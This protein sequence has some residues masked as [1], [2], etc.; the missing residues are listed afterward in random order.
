MP[1]RQSHAWIQILLQALASP[2]D[3]ASRSNRFTHESYIFRYMSDTLGGPRAD[4]NVII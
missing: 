3:E 4:L 2:L 1:P